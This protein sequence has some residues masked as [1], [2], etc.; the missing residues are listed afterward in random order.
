MVVIRWGYTY[1]FS[2]S[3]KIPCGFSAG[4]QTVESLAA[5]FVCVYIGGVS[6]SYDYYS[7]FLLC[8]LVLYLLAFLGSAEAFQVVVSGNGFLHAR[9]VEQILCSF[10]INDTVTMSK[11]NSHSEGYFQ[12]KST[13]C[14]KNF[15]ILC[16]GGRNIF[17]NILGALHF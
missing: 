14:S 10:R 8:S 4:D 17:E 9:N 3:L 12:E 11:S 5:V 6:W 15:C 13:Y 7:T 16:Q 2:F 1:L